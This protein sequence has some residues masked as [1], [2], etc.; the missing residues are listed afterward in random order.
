MKVWKTLLVI[1]VSVVLVFTLAAC[2]K[3]TTTTTT[4]QV[5][6][7][8]KGDISNTITAAGNLALAQTQD[9]P[10]NLFYPNGIKG[11]VS[12]VLVQL[13]DSV[14]AGEVLVT[15]DPDEWNDQLTIVQTAL[16]ASQRSQAT[17]NTS[18]TDAQRQ[19]AN[20]QRAVTTAQFGVVQA[21]QTIADKQLAVAQ[22]QLAVTS[23]NNT[24]YDIQQ[25]QQVQNEI[26][27]ANY[28][29]DLASTIISGGGQAGVVSNLAYWQTLLTSSRQT[30]AQAQADLRAL[31]GGTS[32]TT[33]ADVA[34]LVAQKV[35]ALQAAYVQ[36]ADAQLAASAANNTL[37][38]AQQTVD[39]ANYA[40]T[41]QQQAVQFANLDLTN[42][43]TNLA[44]AQSKLNDAMAMSPQIT[45]PFDG[46]VTA[47]NVKG[48][49]EVL[50]GQIA[51]TIADP[52][53]FQANI[54]VSEM[55]IM[56]V[57][58]GGDAT[59][60]LN[61][62]QGVT[63][64]AKV[65]QIAPTATISSGVVNYAVTVN[66]T[67]VTPVTSR[68]IPASAANATGRQPG[69]AS[70]NFTTRAGGTPSAEAGSSSSGSRAATQ[71][72]SNIQLK[73]GLSGTVSLILSQAT[74]VLL[75]PN[76][77]ITKSGNQSTV[78]VI[79]ANNTIEKRTIQTG[80][81]DYQNTQVTSGLNEGDKIQYSKATSAAPTT[82]TARPGGGGGILFG[83]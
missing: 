66:I 37:A 4:T 27:S 48:G 83:R 8:K 12:S 11:T 54:L 42:A 75:V 67:S 13:G 62:L 5:Y 81:S 65:T 43:N 44:N 63:L 6:T 53:K 70:G 80:L 82:T 77:A 45:A 29:I 15:I 24:L 30:L 64:P 28:A 50:N 40:V 72:P 59:M 55:N 9:L 73:Q 39:D 2:G 36:L 69:G 57:Q 22:A 51:V 52:T 31:L 3:K 56:N 16:T 35:T 14:K 41:K 76:G 17:A 74:A 47:V 1:L 38:S 78:N 21:Q 49:D 61:A 32:A 23:A 79:T 68:S 10:L 26:D 7:V 18:V 71:L 34:L 25:V 20:L 46:F 33:S 58:V 60:T 19:L